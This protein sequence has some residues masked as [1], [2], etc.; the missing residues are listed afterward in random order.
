VLV[1]SA[2]GVRDA[3]PDGVTLD[4][5]PRLMWNPT[6]APILGRAPSSV[7][8]SAKAKNKRAW[9]AVAPSTVAEP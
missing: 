1:G 4:G 8:A 7:Y 9:H 5:P 2:A 6:N 3:H